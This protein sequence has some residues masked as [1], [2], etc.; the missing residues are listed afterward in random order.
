[1]GYWMNGFTPSG[2][3]A[4]LLKLEAS[5]KPVRIGLIGSGMMGTDIVTQVLQMRGIVV[6]AIAD[7]NVPAAIA[8]LAAAGHAPDAHR[9]VNTASA[10][11][12]AI[13]DRR[14]AITPDA[15][16]VCS[17]GLIDVVVDATGKPAVGAQIGLTAMEH[18]KHLVM[19]NVEADVTIGAYL[20]HE[21]DRL[22]VIYS[23]GAGDEPSE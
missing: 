2:L 15:H 18:G 1:M 20:K 7:I 16:L 3:A 23:L 9:V 13:R 21:A 8:A 6:A 10:L 19:M 17:C 5:G 22:G 12:Q 14:I 11:E 4:D